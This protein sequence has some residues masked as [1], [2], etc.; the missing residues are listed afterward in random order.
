[1]VAVITVSC[2]NG[3]MVMQF[4]RNTFS[5]LTVFTGYNCDHFFL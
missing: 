4:H 1:M 2:S 3:S 5:Q